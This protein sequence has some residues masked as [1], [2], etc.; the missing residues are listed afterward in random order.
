MSKNDRHKRAFLTWLAI[1][2][3]ITALF[4]LL[5]NSLAH[6]PLAM[7]T[8][9]LTGLAVPLVS[10]VILPLYTRLFTNWLNQ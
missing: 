4:W 6:Y 5:G 8:F 2:P 3:L 9:V 1:Y 10:Y 7:R